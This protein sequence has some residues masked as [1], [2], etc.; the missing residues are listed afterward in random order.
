[1]VME[2]FRPSWFA[3]YTG[4]NREK[5]VAS[6]LQKK[7][8]E[9]FLPLYGSLRHWKD[10][11]VSLQMPLFPGYLFVHLALCDRLQVLQVPGVVNLVA[12]NGAPVAL[13]QGEIDALKSSLS[14]GISAEPHPYL[15][16]GRK[17]RI[18]RGPLQGW[19]GILIRRKGTFRAVLS[20]EL[21]MRSIAVDV[22]LED[23]DILSP[24]RSSQGHLNA[25]A[26]GKV[27]NTI[28]G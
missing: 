6:A 27:Q 10:R 3:A 18:R 9:H 19:E 8:V 13:P 25:D 1:M 4:A 24:T 5:R 23:V 16:T 12:F 20:V 15:V 28:G 2:Q 11:R 22:D 7:A 14:N 17:V 26:R 21:I